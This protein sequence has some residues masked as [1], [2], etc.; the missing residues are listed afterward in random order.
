MDKLFVVVDTE[1]TGSSPLS[2]DRIIEIAAIP[3]YH[4]KIYYELRFHSLVNPQVTIPASISSIHGLKNADVS[5]E[6]SMLE[7]F[8]RFKEYVGNAVIVGHS[9]AVD[10]KFFDIAAKETGTF[11]FSND[12]IDTYE[13]AKALFNAGP[14]SLAGLARR[15]KIKD[16]PTHRAFDDARVGAKVFLALVERLGGF[17]KLGIYKK[18]WR[19]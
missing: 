11:P 18:R 17:S 4:G 13:L 6:P 1:T 3:I 16:S 9:I 8:P 5:D 19:G 15:L 10:M 2:G 12:Y 7:V 14:Y